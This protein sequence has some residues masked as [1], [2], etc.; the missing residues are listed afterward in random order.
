M[1]NDSNGVILHLFY[2]LIYKVK[3]IVSVFH[4]NGLG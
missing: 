2:F 3:L 1:K 4:S